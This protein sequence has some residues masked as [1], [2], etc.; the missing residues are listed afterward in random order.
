MSKIFISDILLKVALSTITITHYNFEE[1]EVTSTIELN[2]YS[3]FYICHF[4]NGNSKIDSLHE[5]RHIIYTIL[6]Y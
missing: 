1:M 4:P 6:V 5:Q 3:I 2:V